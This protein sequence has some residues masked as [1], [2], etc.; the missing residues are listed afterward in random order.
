MPV[1]KL[2]TLEGLK[3]FFSKFAKV[4]TTGS[5]NDLT[6]KPQITT[7]NNGKLSIKK[8]G[9]LIKE[10]TANQ[11][12]DIIAD[13]SVPTKVSD[14]VN[15]KG[16]VSTD[17]DTTYTFDEGSSRGHFQVTPK[18]G[19]AQSVKI[20]GLGTA[21]YKAEG[22][23]A[24]SNQG[25]KADTSVQ[26]VKIGSTEYKDASGNVTL[27]PYPTSLPASDVQPW[28]KTQTKP[29]YTAVEVGAIP[30]TA[31]G[32][33]G[34]VAEL[35]ENGKIPS[36]QIPGAYDDVKEYDSLSHFPETGEASIIYVDTSTNYE[37]R[38][39]GTTY[40]RL[41]EGV[42]LGET[43]STAYRGDR[44]KAAYDHI[45]DTTKHI[46]S[47]ERTTW[48]NAV[49]VVKI[50]GSEVTKSSGVVNLPAY[51][52]I[53]SS[54]PASN[55]TDTYSATGTAPVSGKAVAAALDTLDVGT[56]GGSGKY[57]QSISETNGKVSAT[58]AD[59][60]TIP[61]KTSQLTNDS[62]FT[63]NE[64]TVT[65][66][67]VGTKEYT[68]S[69]GVVS[70]PAYPTSLPASDVSAWAK[71]SSK[72]TYTASEVGLGNVGNFKAVSTVASQGLSSTEQ[73][74]A[75]TN[76]G[77]GTSS[78]DGKYSSLSGTPTIPT[79]TS[80]LTN[81]SGYTTNTGTVTQVK[82]GTTAYNPTSGV[83]TIPAYPTSLPASD[84]SSW[85]KAS[86]KPTYTASEVG[87]G[88][89]GN[90]KAVS[91]V[92]NQGLTDTEKSNARANIGAG[93]SSFNGAYSSLS[94]RPT[95]GTAAAKNVPSS[96]NAASSEV[97]LGSD[98]R[99][100]NSRPASDVYSWAKASTKPSYTAS[101]VGAIEAS[102]KGAINGV[103][104][105]DANGKVPSSQLP[106]FVDDVLEGYLYNSKFYKESTHTTEI[107][108][109]SGKI[110]IDLATNKT[111]RW[112]GTAFAVVSETLAIGETSST[113]YRGDRGKAAYDH[114][115]DTTKHI[116]S[117]ERTA[118]NGAV[119]TVKINGTEITKSSGVVNLPAYPTIPSSLPASNVT[120]TYSATGTA[121]VSGKAVA[122]ALGTLDVSS[123]GGSGK[124]IQSISET[125]GKISATAGT[126][127]TSLPASDVSAW[128][129][130]AT[131]PTYTAS[132][133]GLGNVGNFKAVSTVAS[134]GL[135]ST[136]QANA[137][138][139]IGA[140]TSSFDGKY[141]SLSGTP[142]IPTKTSQLTND[143]GYTTNT[144]TVT[145][146]KVG[147]TS[148]SPSSGVVTIPAYP[149]SLP[150][151]D[152]YSWAK[153]SSKPTYTASEVGLG[154][155]G[156]FKAVSTVASQGL[157]AAEKL[158]ARTNI[159]AGTSS[160][161]IN[162]ST[163]STTS[164]YSSSKT[165]EV[166]D[167]M[168]GQAVT[169]SSIASNVINDNKKATTTTYSSSKIEEMF[170]YV[171]ATWSGAT[172]AQIVDAIAKADA[173]AF[174]PA[175][176]W[177]VGDIRTVPL[178][179]IAAS[180]GVDETQDAQDVSL[181]IV[182]LGLYKDM[183]DK[184][185]NAIVQLQHNLNT[186]GKMNATNTNAGSWNSCPRRTWC[187][188]NFYNAIPSTIRAIFKK[189]QTV[190]AKEQSSSELTT[191]L[192]YFA[193]P[194][195]KEVF[196][197]KKYSTD[198]EAAALTQWDYYKV[199]VNRIKQT[200]T[201]DAAWWLRSPR[202]GNTAYFCNVTT[203]GTANGIANANT[204]Y[205]LAPF[206]CI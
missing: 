152:V 129:K 176:Y 155:V 186:N 92:A 100:T 182:H 136:E 31:K 75:R 101:E 109:E 24:T 91:T 71:A 78:F 66:I 111:Y 59:F 74:N 151:S 132:E 32:S 159:G 96:G 3:R 166:I 14:L 41:N 107:S 196:G 115:S 126:M 191:S 1:K 116:T 137:R 40:V 37:Y 161:A 73:A 175:N 23:F 135:S 34:G 170:G 112:S 62:G 197:A 184:T 94:G 183:N 16:F 69:S 147:T 55:V 30:S 82:V 64:G 44:G 178:S 95:L 26:S 10:F 104:E 114:I 29:A 12:N 88:N 148:Y 140:G 122:A 77:A 123:V 13:I 70:I 118:W 189:F 156:N 194:A 202:A 17:T 65:T 42:A 49:Q 169:P 84:V 188:S 108:G 199:T 134:Q 21:A 171:E 167:T 38:W 46:T 138:A 193:L 98:T 5:Y 60:P 57:I 154:N 63:S 22:A 102:A 50:N 187:N 113:A 145:G 105:L 45:S 124:F 200:S 58:A 54:L 61:T 158:N 203:S 20:H 168:I 128:A 146:I 149:T 2:I 204:A 72:P 51:P 198:A 9:T 172:D 80:Q 27:P 36:S 195:E 28:A 110:Y 181:V 4:A 205:G 162:D 35:D 6:D 139:N 190:T 53:P 160:L 86:T 67:N 15:D 142:T 7:A 120:D 130:A 39:S 18:D 106:S 206:G 201:S 56:M 174:S 127:P 8:N 133:V 48:N 180:T 173:G 11:S 97:V 79:K 163:K 85:A 150:A 157:T 141:S 179:S 117:S 76:I 19:E 93:T 43:S 125:D 177:A 87:L 153:A 47:N 68:P 52:T 25:S 81:D 33:N 144:G 164:V 192:D 165:E 121:P 131:K 83:V 185:V 99:L 89:V 143:S 119:Q 103:A 90:Y